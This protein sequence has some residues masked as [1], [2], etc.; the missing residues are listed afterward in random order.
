M[1]RNKERQP[2][3]S[4]CQLNLR[5]CFTFSFSNLLRAMNSRVIF[6]DTTIRLWKCG[7]TKSTANAPASPGKSSTLMSSGGIVIPR[8]T[9]SLPETGENSGDKRS[10]W[11]KSWSDVARQASRRS[12]IVSAFKGDA[13][14][15]NA[16]SRSG[17]SVS[18]TS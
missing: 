5:I 4:T 7:I 8:S 11:N 10:R 1:G 18:S 14:D 3:H 13:Y 17:P 12:L 16:E 2:P 6:F 9:W 15:I